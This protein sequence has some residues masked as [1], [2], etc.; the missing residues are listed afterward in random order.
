MF[1]RALLL[2]AL[3]CI[4]ST[5][6]LIDHS[7]WM[8][9]LTPA[10]TAKP[11]INLAIPGSHDSFTETLEHNGPVANDESQKVKELLDALEGILGNGVNKIIRN[12]SVTQHFNVSAQLMGGIRFFDFR[13]SHP[14]KPNGTDDVRIVHGLYGISLW[15]LLPPIN[16]FLTAH[17]KE[18]VILQLG[19]FYNYDQTLHTLTH[20]RLTATFGTKLCPRV[21][22]MNSLTLDYAR[23]QAGGGC[24]IILIYGDESVP[25]PSN[26]YHAYQ[27]TSP[28]ANT[29]NMTTL[30]DFL[31]TGLQTRPTDRFFVSQAIRTEQVKDIVLHLDS[32]LERFLANATTAMAVTWLKSNMSSVRPKLN[33]VIVDFVDKFDYVDAVLGCD[34]FNS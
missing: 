22:N 6:S 14:D 9:Q 5:H 2:T 24:Q 33:I 34:L 11:M 15:Q 8:S 3:V 13:M 20:T 30:M 1:K 7:N 12:W 27:L 28:W 17:S 16:D 32:S 21:D 31:V 4:E 23:A 18:L 29:D 10:E 25:L 19:A 26:F